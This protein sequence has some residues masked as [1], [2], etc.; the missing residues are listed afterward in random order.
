M[1]GAA[2]PTHPRGARASGF[3]LSP[4]SSRALDCLLRV[5]AS[6]CV[7]CML[8]HRPYVA[9]CVRRLCTS[10][11]CCAL[12]VECNASRMLQVVRCP[13]LVA[14]EMRQCR[15]CPVASRMCSRPLAC[16]LLSVARCL[17][18]ALPGGCHLLRSVCRMPH[19]ALLSGTRRR[20]SFPRCLWSVARYPL[21]VAW[22]SVALQVVVVRGIL[23]EV[24]RMVHDARP[25]LH[26]VAWP[27]PVPFFHVACR[28]PPVARCRVTQRRHTRSASRR[29]SQLS[30][31]VAGEP[32][33]SAD[34]GVRACARACV[35]ACVSAASVTV[36][37]CACVGSIR[38]RGQSN[39]RDTNV[40]CLRS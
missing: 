29:R 14:H 12:V 30:A 16:R 21:P 25:L 11:P 4:L 17:L 32:R 20:L 36:C 15:V 28:M 37:C 10:V 23:H 40:A 7:C 39:K 9:S 3:H 38:A 1:A 31:S 26:A 13:L 5:V 8:R 6:V 33:C 22:V 19:V 24:W 34:R 27:L 2:S 35:R 18:H